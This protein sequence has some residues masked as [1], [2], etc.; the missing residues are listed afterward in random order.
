MKKSAFTLIE[1]LI[2]ILMPA[3]NKAKQLA[4]GAVCLNNEANLAKAW[5]RVNEGGGR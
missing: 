2:G 5:V 1:L 4:T 3:L